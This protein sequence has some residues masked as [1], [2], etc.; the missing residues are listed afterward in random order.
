MDKKAIGERIRLIRLSKGMT[1]EEFGKLF[2]QAKALYQD[3]KTAKV[4]HA[5]NGLRN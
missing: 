3:G 1:L 2:K 4:C 5:P